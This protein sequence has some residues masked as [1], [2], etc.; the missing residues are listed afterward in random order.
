MYMPRKLRIYILLVIFLV[1]ILTRGYLLLT[2]RHDESIEEPPVEAMSTK[3]QENLSNEAARE[4]VIKQFMEEFLKTAPPE[5]DEQ[6]L[7]NAINLFTEEA[8]E[9]IPTIDGKYHL[10]MLLGVRDLPDNGYEISDTLLRPDPVTEQPG[11]LANVG[12]ILKYSSGQQTVRVFNLVK[13][14]EGWKI[15]GVGSK[16]SP[17]D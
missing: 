15:E 12:V 10:G 13:V 5:P 3:V 1:I 16:L 4:E 14:N 6:A 7:E 17:D 9:G 8:K 11:M 2:Q